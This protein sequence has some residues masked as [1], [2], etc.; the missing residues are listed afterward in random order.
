MCCLP[1]VTMFTS[2]DINQNCEQWKALNKRAM[3]M[4]DLCGHVSHLESCHNSIIAA[5][6][7]HSKVSFPILVLAIDLSG[8]KIWKGS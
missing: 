1:W 6:A 3:E 7:G 4:T 5:A 2:I 8:M